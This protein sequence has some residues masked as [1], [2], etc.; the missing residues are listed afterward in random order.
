MRIVIIT[1]VLMLLLFPATSVM[2]EDVTTNLSYD[3]T[4]IVNDERVIFPDQKPFI[5]TGTGR[6]YVP[7][8][9]VTEKL[10]AGVDWNQQ[11][12]IAVIQK[13]DK[14]IKAPVGSDRPTVN[15]QAVYLDA[16]VKLIN[17][18]TVV[19]LRFMSETLGTEVQ[20]DS[21]ARTVYIK[22]NGEPGETTDK[23][24]DSD[25]KAITPGSIVEVT[26]DVLNVRSGPGT[27]KPKI[28]K[29]TKG[30]KLTVIES[31]EGWCKVKL[32]D[33]K[34]GWV[35]DWFI[36]V[37]HEDYE[38]PNEEKEEE[39][40]NWK[41]MDSTLD[42]LTIQ[43]NGDRT[44][45]IITTTGPME[46]D[47]F[48]LTG[49]DQVVVDLKGVKP[50]DLPEEVDVDND[51]VRR[52][53]TGKFSEDPSIVRL[54]FDVK[55]PVMFNATESIKN[56]GMEL[57]LELYSP[58]LGTHLK[59]K[60]IAIDPGHGGSDPG[61][62]GPTGLKEKDVNIDVGL[63]TAHLLTQ[64]G[65]DVVL[66]RTTDTYVDLYERTRIAG[67]A[68]ADVF[69]SIH[70]NAHPSEGIDGTST[71]YRRD[72]VSGPGVSQEDNRM[73]AR[74]VHSQLL[75]YLNR[76]DAGI[77]Q[78]NFVVLRTA[79]MPAVLVEASFIS[80]SEEEKLLRKDSYRAKIAEAITRGIANYFAQKAS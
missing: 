1:T 18:R 28:G 30:D 7:L 79:A 50:G 80:N 11:E 29:V 9:F 78:A 22:T 36:E 49:P 57:K 70:M 19:P 3:V 67:A 14:T 51:L 15:G 44:V 71:F 53:R 58:D 55:K 33:G 41:S 13:G 12:K 76:R 5:D 52:L 74:H 39:E 40:T 73:L 31:L 20:W 61:A 65:A 35:A 75:Q 66:T 32:A 6:T 69:V 21:T 23:P 17:A 54:V 24:G 2:A 68:G 45:A 26:A 47:I 25:K 27:S 63:L 37:S 64:S 4:V 56:D 48:T 38:L 62:I 42:D 16:P 59:G 72:N 60:T 10:G 77:H 46:N 34:I 8:R 43:E